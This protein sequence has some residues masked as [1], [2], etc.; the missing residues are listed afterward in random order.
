[1][2]KK[3]IITL[4][5]FFSFNTVWSQSKQL[6]FKHLDIED[7]LSLSSVYTI[8]QDSK[9]FMWFGTEDGLNRYDGKNFRIFRPDA[10][11]PNSISHKWIDQI[12]EDISGILWFGSRAG[13]TSFN[14]KK[15]IFTQYKNASV[16]GNKLSN[17]TIICLLED[18]EKQLWVGTLGGIN[19]IDLATGKSTQFMFNDSN[20]SR[21]NGRINALLLIGNGNVLIGSDGGLFVFNK[22]EKN[23]SK[24]K[25]QISEEQDIRVKSMSEGKDRLWLGTNLGLV[26]YF[27]EKKL[28]KLYSIP[29]SQISKEPNQFIENLYLSSSGIPKRIR[30][31]FQVTMLEG[32]TK[33]VVGCYGS[34]QF[35]G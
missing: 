27:P 30:P 4:L 10:S 19:K 28:V 21:L 22:S 14:P 29:S 33:I 17:D 34:V 26:S 24:I 20:L 31:P 7:G 13:L 5:I 35:R 9:G 23:F 25:I 6:R 8:F 15:E 1:M 3:P 12:Y 16:E 32:F 18:N 11:N 2:I